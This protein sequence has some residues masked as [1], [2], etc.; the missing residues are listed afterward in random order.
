MRAGAFAARKVPVIIGIY[1]P[2]I[3][4]AYRS[5]YENSIG[6]KGLYQFLPQTAK[7][8]GVA[9]GEMCDVEKMTP[10]ATT[11]RLIQSRIQRAP[12]TTRLDSS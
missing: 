5:C 6:A 4:S 2:M 9:H 11:A 12:E 10:A 7:H 3:E 8:Y 1:L